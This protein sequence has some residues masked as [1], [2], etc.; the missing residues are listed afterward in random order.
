M[1]GDLYPVAPYYLVGGTIDLNVE[2]VDEKDEFG[3]LICCEGTIQYEEG[4]FPYKEDPYGRADLEDIVGRQ[5]TEYMHTKD[6]VLGI[7][8]YRFERLT[9]GD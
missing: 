5:E 4:E 6:A 2:R 1:D 8:E 3:N 7:R 9:S